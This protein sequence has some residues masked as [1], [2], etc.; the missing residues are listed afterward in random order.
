MTPWHQTHNSASLLFTV[1]TQKFDKSLEEQKHHCLRKKA[2]SAASRHIPLTWVQMSVLDHDYTLVLTPELASARILSSEPEEKERQ[3]GIV[4]W[5]GPNNWFCDFMLLLKM[6]LTQIWS[7]FFKLVECSR[8]VLREKGCILCSQ[9]LHWTKVKMLHDSFCW[10]LSWRTRNVYCSINI[11]KVKFAGKQQRNQ[12]SMSQ[13]SAKCHS[14]LLVCWWVCYVTEISLSVC[15]CV[16][17]SG[18]EQNWLQL[19]HRRYAVSY[20]HLLSKL[21]QSGEDFHFLLR[22]I[23]PRQLPHNDVPIH[24]R[25][26][27]QTGIDWAVLILNQQSQHNHILAISSPL[28]VWFSTAPVAF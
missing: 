3:W 15:V 2:N 1:R 13:L 27:G 19:I 18:A 17:E 26:H 23:V 10:R 9:L 14:G 22:V 25:T 7:H 6:N 11:C 20:R 12:L 8:S 21:F 5:A 24:L 4:K 28:L 16:R